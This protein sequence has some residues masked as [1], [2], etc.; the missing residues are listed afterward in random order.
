MFWV[1]VFSLLLSVQ[2][3]SSLLQ[4]P[5]ALTILYYTILYY[6][7]LYY[8]ILYT[9]YYAHSPGGVIVKGGWVV[10]LAEPKE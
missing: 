4:H 6:T 7:I 8:T 10:K 2:K 5:L 3:T 9:L 1:R